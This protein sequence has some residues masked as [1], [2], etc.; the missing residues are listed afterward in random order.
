MS[1]HNMFIQ[2][3]NSYQKPIIKCNAEH[4]NWMQL[5][6]EQFFNNAQPVRDKNDLARGWCVYVEAL[7]FD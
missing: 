7:E 2:K 6:C 3:V 1:D 4:S 5:W